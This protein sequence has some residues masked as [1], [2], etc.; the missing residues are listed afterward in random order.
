MPQF[1]R[2]HGAV[3]RDNTERVL[4]CLR[5]ISEEDCE[6]TDWELVL[7]PDSKTPSTR[8]EIRARCALGEEQE[9]SLRYLGERDKLM[10]NVPK[11]ITLIRE[12]VEVQVDEN[13]MDFMGLMGYSMDYEFVRKGWRFRP[14]INGMEMLA[15]LF[16]LCKIPR[17]HAIDE[18]EPMDK[19]HVLEISAV[20]EHPRHMPVVLSTCSRFA[21]SLSPDFAVVR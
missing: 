7:K 18:A 2:S 20:C 19:S 6:F 9:W 12:E 11:S 13:A 4:E 8:P 16:M 17:R 21:E 10:T 3:E 5:N 1:V 15:E 14:V